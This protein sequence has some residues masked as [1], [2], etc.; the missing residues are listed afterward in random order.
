ML[1]EE[2]EEDGEDGEGRKEVNL[3]SLVSA[4]TALVTASLSTALFS[5]GR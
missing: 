4:S 1:E 3:G 2:E 5:S